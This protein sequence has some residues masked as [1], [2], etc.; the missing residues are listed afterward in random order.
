MKYFLLLQKFLL[1]LCNEGV[2]APFQWFF[3]VILPCVCGR[4]N[5]AMPDNYRKGKSSQQTFLIRSFV[6]Y[7]I[8]A[9]AGMVS[10]IRQYQVE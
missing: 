9:C 3:N 6:V 5:S 8:P 1:T 10:V 4:K 7:W 2:H